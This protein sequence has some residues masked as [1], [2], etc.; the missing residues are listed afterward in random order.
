MKFDDYNGCRKRRGR[1]LSV[2]LLG[3]VFL[4][5]GVLAGSY[6]WYT[7]QLKP[8]S[9]TSEI[10]EIITVPVGSTIEDIANQLEDKA[11]IRSATAFD[12]YTRFNSSVGSLQAGGY[13][14]SP[15]MSVQEILSI[16]TSGDV[17]SDLIT[18]LPGQRLD[19]IMA[20]LITNAGYT[21][22]AVEVAFDPAQYNDHPALQDKPVSA[23]LEGYLYP[24]S[25]LRQAGEPLENIIRQALDQ[26]ALQ[27]T[28][29]IRSN[30]K[31]QGLTVHQAI[32]LASIVDREVSI[33]DDKPVVAQVFLRR[34]REGIMLGSDA[35]ALY[36]AE[37]AGLDLAIFA[38]TPYNTRLYSGLP[39]GP[40]SNVSASAL[41]AIA[42]PAKTDYLYFVSGDDGLTYFS[43]TLREH[44]AA[45]ALHCIELCSLY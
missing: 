19:L 44:E 39:P 27:L 36:G 29:A 28:D 5:V 38:D 1:A 40:I 11:I 16:L 12:L 9:D 31:E 6:I 2:A 33:V 25:Y 7:A 8:I 4:V 41:A 15:S 3:F 20:S 13:R 34:Y 26:T 21:R 18:F 22:E 42:N 17:A 37:V 14:L 35:T 45:T 10:Q 43:N 23:S 24:E 30:I 32:I